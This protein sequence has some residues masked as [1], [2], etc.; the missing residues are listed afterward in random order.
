[1]ALLVCKMGKFMKKRDYVQEREE[2]T[3]R[4]MWGYAISV[5][6]QITL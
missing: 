5:R 6:A 2:I 4:S 1:M 3:W